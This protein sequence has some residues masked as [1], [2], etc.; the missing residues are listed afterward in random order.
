MG[1]YVITGIVKAVVNWKIEERNLDRNRD[2][3]YLEGRFLI[4]MMM[5]RHSA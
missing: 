2:N 4:A 3:P 5:H 1:V